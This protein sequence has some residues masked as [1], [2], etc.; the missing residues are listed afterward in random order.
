MSAEVQILRSIPYGRTKKG[1]ATR[2]RRSG[3][4]KKRWAGRPG[5]VFFGFVFC[6]LVFLCGGLVFAAEHA[7]KAGPP[8]YRVFPL[9][10][11][12]AEQ[13][14]EYLTQLEIGTVSQLPSPNTLLVTASA[15][16]LLKISAILELVD[17]EQRYVVKPIFAVSEAKDLPSNE[18]IA[19]EAGNISIGTFSDPPAKGPKT[20]VIIDIHD[21]A[22]LA[23]AP[24][25]ELEKII[26][27]IGRIQDKEIAALQPSEPSESNEPRQPSQPAEPNRPSELETQEVAPAEPQ[28]TPGPNEPM[29]EADAQQLKSDEPD[30]FLD[31]LLERLAEVEKTMAEPN[32]GGAVAV[33]PEV[34]EPTE[35]SA[36][37]EKIE[38]PTPQPA[39]QPQESKEAETE[40]KTADEE[41]QAQVP[42]EPEAEEEASEIEETI[43][44]AEPT[45]QERVYEPE[46]IPIGEEELTLDLPEKLNVV[47][48]LDLVGKYLN[49][50]YMYDPAKVKGEVTLKLQGPVKV[51]ELYPL[52]ESVLK[53][54]NFVM[55]RKGNLVTIVPSGEVPEIDPTLMY[56]EKGKVEY[57]DVIVT[58]LFDLQYM[59][60]ASAKNFL[61]Q[62]R[63]GANM[64]DIADTGT[65]IVTDYAYRMG[66]IEELLE[67]IDKPGEPKQFRSRQLKYTMA[68]TLAPKV[69]TLVEQL[70]TISITVA[71]GA[72][73]TISRR[74]GESAAA[75]RRREAAARRGAPATPTPAKPTVYLDADERTNRILMIGFENELAV[76]DELID[77]LDV[78]Q[79]DLRTLRLYD[80]QHV[81]AQEVKDKLQELGIIGGGRAVP[82]ARAVPA[83]A[84]AP[85]APA[86]VGEVLAEEPQV[87]IVES[88]NSLLVN[89]TAEQHIQI[90]TIIGYVDSVTLAEAIPYEIYPLENQ[91]PVD[92]AEVLEQLIQET[93]KDKEGKI[94]QVIKKEEDIEI[95]PD[96][97]TFSLIVY[98]SK[99]NQE[100]I[101]KLIKTLDQR[102]PQVL[103][104][105]SLVEVTREDLFEFDLN[106]IAN[107]RNAVVGNIGV[108]GSTLPLDKSIGNELE[109]GWNLKDSEGKNKGVVQ[110]FYGEDKIQAL[111]TAMDKKDY[112]RILA[113][114]KVLVNDNEEGLIKTTEKTHVEESTTSYTSEGIPLTTTKYVP[115][116]AKI[117]LTITP[118]ISEGDLLRLEINMLRED[119]QRQEQGPPDY[120]TSNITTIVTVP[121]GSTIILG[122]LTKLKQTKAGSKVPLLGDIPLVGGLFRTI[123]N[124]DDSSKLY[125]FVKANIL[126]PDE[127]VGLAQL[128]QISARNRAAFEEGER[129]FQQK[130]D[131]PGIKPEPMEPLRILEAE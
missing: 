95:V 45:V 121:D 48:L 98:A 1:L 68:K 79:R 19:S 67:I 78:E 128:Q 25:E 42:A 108:F 119:F 38:Q 14:K 71:R 10:H 32:E 3:E 7:N 41:M 94:Q 99:K 57:G 93:V 102:R 2:L 120:T 65:L 96:E 116:E 46:P 20:M 9:R 100:W 24:A 113:Q 110:G 90:A 8:R 36:G 21:D 16:E 126:R 74:S 50:D 28:K 106:I 85:A 104:D 122:G 107:A 91:N 31:K 125:V 59:N 12:S 49:L 6:F 103:I 18:E 105:V 87:V 84:G 118:N 52:A 129:R 80:I 40:G 109:G 77:T 58:R 130:E 35:P 76:V 4:G 53:F 51:K 97:N 69:K 61:S 13:G 75:F 34:N 15:S 101:K 23:V 73:P 111:L 26:A 72:A 115:Y 123:A 55:T 70:G 60:T 29:Q 62:M 124:S 44:D 64:T 127:T 82:S 30:E 63:L 117:E 43:A 56:D 11:I 22:V 88:T 86:R 39:E 81:D 66:R 54:R 47:D 83:R 92:L 112:G 33:V 131:W 5:V 114:P 17:A 27:A 89:A 37:G